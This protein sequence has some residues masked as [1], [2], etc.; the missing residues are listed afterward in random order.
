MNK[1]NINPLKILIV[2]DDEIS[3]KVTK[4]ILNTYY[5]CEIDLAENATDAFDIIKDKSSNNYDLILM[6]IFLP[7]LNGDD[8]T[9][10]IRKTEIQ[11][12]SIPIIAVSG[13]ASKKDEKMFKHLGITDLLLKPLS[14]ESLDD[15]LTKHIK[16]IEHYKRRI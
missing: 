7:D 15:L 1:K 2:E 12:N 3:R 13:K 6:D 5:I 16:E 8:L 9:E 10:I 11:N 4:E 14:F